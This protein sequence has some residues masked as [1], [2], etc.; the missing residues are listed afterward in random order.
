M[1]GGKLA[2]L[3]KISNSSPIVGKTI[4]QAEK[5][6]HFRVGCAAF[7]RAVKQISPANIVAL[8]PVKAQRNETKLFEKKMRL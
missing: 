6:F 5:I 3:K 4:F 1:N 2:N 8:S 7:L